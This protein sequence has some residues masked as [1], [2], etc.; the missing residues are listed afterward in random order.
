MEPQQQW[1]PAEGSEQV[2]MVTQGC[3]TFQTVVGAV[4]ALLQVFRLK[5]QK[6]LSAGLRASCN[7][8]GQPLAP[9]RVLEMRRKTATFQVQLGPELQQGTHVGPS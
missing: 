8:T 4:V 5:L 9:T 3:E 6:V 7:Y 2:D 1:E